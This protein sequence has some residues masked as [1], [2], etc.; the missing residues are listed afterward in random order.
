MSC[1]AAALA[2]NIAPT[3]L[4]SLFLFIP[5]RSLF[6]WS[7]RCLLVPL[8]LDKSSANFFSYP[9]MFLSTPL[10]I[11]PSPA[12]VLPGPPRYVVFDFGFIFPSSC[13]VC[14]S[15]LAID[16][17]ILV[18]AG[19]IFCTTFIAYSTAALPNI[20]TLAC[21]VTDITIFTRLFCSSGVKDIGSIASTCSIIG[22]GLLP[23]ARASSSCH[24]N[25]SLLGR[26]IDLLYM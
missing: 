17:I 26:P 3:S 2:P 5:I 8:N 12:K 21:G 11:L 10:V 15:P 1:L 19:F 25:V 14:K 9:N 23:T 24:V 22:A 4:E 6:L 18:P 7:K 20:A 16:G 13:R